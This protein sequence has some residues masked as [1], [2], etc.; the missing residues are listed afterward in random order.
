MR[1]FQTDLSYNDEIRSL[2]HMKRQCSRRNK[3]SIHNF[4]STE[5]DVESSQS[6]YTCTVVVLSVPVA[7]VLQVCGRHRKMYGPGCLCLPVKPKK[8]KKT[9]QCINGHVFV[10]IFVTVNYT[11]WNLHSLSFFTVD[12]K[13]YLWLLNLLQY[14]SSGTKESESETKRKCQSP[15]FFH[16]AAY[17]LMSNQSP[18]NLHV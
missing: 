11:V 12:Y 10:F 14:L 17:L 18:S 8:T 5:R 9:M 4:P 16:V 3:T 1:A 2:I 7:L 6:S 15:S 13:S